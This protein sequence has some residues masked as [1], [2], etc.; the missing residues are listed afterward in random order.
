MLHP[1][2]PIA[3][4]AKPDAGQGPEGLPQLTVLLAAPRGFCAGVRRAIQAVR[5][6]LAKHG[7]PV[8]VRRAIVHNMEVVRELEREGA[9]FIKEVHEAPPGSVIIFSAHGVAP[10]V[11]QQ[12]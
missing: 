10:E 7:A 1:S 9:I 8:Y 6:A 3:C 4:R 5:D 11:A 2:D 12:A